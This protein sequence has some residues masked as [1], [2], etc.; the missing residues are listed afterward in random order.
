MNLHHAACHARA[1]TF[2][3]GHGRG[4]EARAHAVEG[5][6]GRGLARR[7]S[8]GAEPRRA[9]RSG[10]GVGQRGRQV[11]D[12]EG[13]ARAEH[14]H[15]QP[16]RAG[17]DRDWVR[18]RARAIQRFRAFRSGGGFGLEAGLEDGGT[19]LGSGQNPAR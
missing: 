15:A 2:E 3:G 13:E 10:G 14:R 16:S 17:R 9:H 18:L 11:A 19:G 12:G 8:G 4:V 5:A 7:G 1:R 6:H